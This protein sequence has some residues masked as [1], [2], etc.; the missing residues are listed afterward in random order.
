[1]AFRVI[2]VAANLHVEYNT[3]HE[4]LAI[5]DALQ[6]R[7]GARRARKNRYGDELS[8]TVTTSA[9]ADKELV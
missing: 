2:L 3:E 1:M 8:G 9:P 7:Y 5:V 4:D 6:S